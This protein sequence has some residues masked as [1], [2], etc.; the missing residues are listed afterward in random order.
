MSKKRKKKYSRHPYLQKRR[1]GIFY[2]YHH[3]QGSQVRISTRSRKRAVAEDAL[4]LYERD[5]AVGRS[6]VAI[7]LTMHSGISKWLADRQSTRNGLKTSTLSGYKTFAKKLKA[8]LPPRLLVRDF[9][10]EHVRLALDKLA[11]SGEGQIQVAKCQTA[12]SQVCNFLI[13]EGHLTFNPCVKVAPAAQYG[14]QVAMSL[15]EYEEL[16]AAME[17]E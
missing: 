15:K 4:R 11:N 17:T 2:I 8:A 1:T 14:K 3:Q 10:R 13:A 9:R 7:T 6:P 5:L 16:L 12:L